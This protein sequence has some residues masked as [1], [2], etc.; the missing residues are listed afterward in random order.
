MKGD[1]VLLPKLHELFGNARSVREKRGVGGGCINQTSLLTLDDGT[2]VFL[3]ENSSRYEGLF[4][5]ES[6]GLEALASREGPRV[7]RPYAFWQTAGRQYLLIEYVESGTKRAGFWEDFGRRLARLHRERRSDRFGFA[8]DNHI[9]ATP[10]QNGWM[11]KWVSFFGERRLRYQLELAGRNGHA[12]ARWF[13]PL[14]SL[15][16]HLDRYLAEPEQPSL[17]HGD[18][19]G[20]NYMVDEKGDAV[21]IDPAVYY[22]NREADIAMT[23]LFGGFDPRFYSAYDEE[24]ARSPG[25]SER[26]DLYNLYHLL[27]HLNLFGGSYAGSVAATVERYR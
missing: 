25:Y 5:A 17:L 21:L 18:L 1:D 9:G 6:A 24:Y 4:E 26:R 14:E 13:R 8:L 19:W 15:I 10:Q 16:G 20:G 23:E 3:K 2:R 22:G 12:G 7:P 27:N 11:D